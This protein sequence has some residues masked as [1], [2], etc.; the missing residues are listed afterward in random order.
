[1]DTNLGDALSGLHLLGSNSNNDSDDDA[2]ENEI[3]MLCKEDVRKLIWDRPDCL[4][5]FGWS[6]G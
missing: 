6:D 1:M 2:T 3:A 4:T 5:G